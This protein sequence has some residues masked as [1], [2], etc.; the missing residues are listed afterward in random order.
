M[1]HQIKSSN[2]LAWSGF[3]TT[4]QNE[5]ILLGKPASLT[6]S[7]RVLR[8]GHGQVKGYLLLSES[9]RHTG[10]Q[11]TTFLVFSESL[12]NLPTLQSQCTCSRYNNKSRKTTVMP[13]GGPSCRGCWAYV[14]AGDDGTTT[15]TSPTT[16]GRYCLSP[17]ADLDLDRQCHQLAT[18]GLGCS[19]LGAVVDNAK[20]TADRRAGFSFIGGVGGLAHSQDR[21]VRWRARSCRDRSRGHHHNTTPIR[22]I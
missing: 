19:V 3:S 15:L 20:S 12:K 21:P 6:A 14:L 17:P 8:F 4:S 2:W 22:F 5:T 18:H 13:A 10:C 1:Q 16:T 7:R 9:C 11:G